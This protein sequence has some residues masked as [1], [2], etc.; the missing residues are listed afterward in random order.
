MRKEKVQHAYSSLA[1]NLKDVNLK[2]LFANLCKKIKHQL[3]E[4]G[5]CK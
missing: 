3:N 5:K 4:R 1:Y 2:T